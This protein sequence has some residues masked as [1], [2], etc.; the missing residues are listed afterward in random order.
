MFASSPAQ[1][2][3]ERT[4]LSSGCVWSTTSARMASSCAT[5]P[6]AHSNFCALSFVPSL[7]SM[8]SLTSQMVPFSDVFAN[9]HTSP[10][11]IAATICKVTVPSKSL[12]IEVACPSLGT[13]AAIGGRPISS[14]SSSSK[15]KYRVG[16]CD[17]SDAAPVCAGLL[18]SNT[19]C[20]Q[21]WQLAVQ[22]KLARLPLVAFSC[23][24]ADWK[25]RAA[26]STI[27]H[28]TTATMHGNTVLA[29]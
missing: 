18:F 29:A 24:S 6:L 11:V 14:S 27:C 28:G 22:P 13:A 7:R 17:H 10:P 26:C 16:F 19:S 1:T 4:R 12:R 20:A 23:C 3:G 2:G 8:R 15:S 5:W 9:E 25:S 21:I